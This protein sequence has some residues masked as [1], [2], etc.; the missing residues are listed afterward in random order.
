[1]GPGGDG[2]STPGKE[3]L[4][5]PRTPKIRLKRTKT[6][7]P[8]KENHKETWVSETIIS[9]VKA[10]AVAAGGPPR[11]MDEY[12][13]PDV[14]PVKEVLNSPWRG[15][16]GGSPALAASGGVIKGATFSPLS[17]ASIHKL[18]TSPLLH[19]AQVIT[20]KV[21]VLFLP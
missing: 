1:M 7:D 5:S 3:N 9:P 12:E 2:P 19:P 17:S 16:G 18:H 6:L 20:A 4:G 8:L 13:Y 14:S 11:L 10:P 21:F 15:A